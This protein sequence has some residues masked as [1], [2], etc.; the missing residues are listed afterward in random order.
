MGSMRPVLSV[1]LTCCVL[2]ALPA[3]VEAQISRDPAVQAAY[4]AGVKL[5]EEEKY[6]EA[7]VEF[8]KA[9]DDDTFA[10][11]FLGQGDALRM[12][13]DYQA[14]I[15]SYTKAR[16]RNQQLPRAHFGLGMCHKELGQYDL[17]MNDFMNAVDQDR[18]DPE[19]A[20]NLGK[21]YLDI[22]DATNA[23]RTLQTAVELDP[24]NAEVYS[25][26]GW[27][28]TRLRQ[29]DEGIVNLKESLELDP[30]NYESHLRLSNVYLFLEEYENAI[31]SLTSAIK[32]YEPEESL[33]PDIFISGYIMRADT[34]MKLAGEETTPEEEREQLYEKVLADAQTVLDEYPDRFPESGN[35][36]Y[37]K[38]RALRMLF[39]YGEAIKT[40]TD[41]IQMVPG[42]DASYLGEAYLKR[43]ICW[44][45]QQEPDLARRDFEQAAS[46]N[47]E[48]PLP[49]FWVGLTHAQE[50]EYRKAIDSYGDAIAKNPTQTSA[51]VNR[52]L[53]YMQEEDYQKAVDNFNEAIRLEPTESEHFYKRGVA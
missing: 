40:L 42:G 7:I 34:E 8:S 4:D 41:A 47:Y 5:L 52:G 17:A 14:A 18:R 49:Y 27:A 36:L 48:D 35:A 31:D 50:E 11:A 28:Y 22:G 24:D 26:L 44:L 46:L 33:D 45:N 25:D 20:A 15:Q 13:E 16:D 51:Y 23:L 32:Y 37:F 3:P 10:E 19:I 53:A 9:T 6:E 43:G 21:L 39:R 1:V 38:G 30:E 2:L 29:T 12:L